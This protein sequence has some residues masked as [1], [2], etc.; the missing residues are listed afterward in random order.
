MPKSSSPPSSDVGFEKYPQSQDNSSFPPTFT[1]PAEF[2][3]WWEKT[4]AQEE[5]NLP[6]SYDVSHL[7]GLNGDMDQPKDEATASAASRYDLR[8][9]KTSPVDNTVKSVIKTS[10]CSQKNKTPMNIPRSPDTPTRP[11]KAKCHSDR[12]VRPVPAFAVCE[13]KTVSNFNRRDT[14]E[15]TD[16]ES[17]SQTP[18]WAASKRARQAPQK[19]DDDGDEL[20]YVDDG[21]APAA[22][23]IL[24]VGEASPDHQHSAADPDL[25]G[26]MHGLAGGV[27]PDPDEEKK[28][29]VDNDVKPKRKNEDD[30]DDEADAHTVKKIKPSASVTLQFSAAG[31]TVDISVNCKINGRNIK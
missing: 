7:V 18:L 4:R 25:D 5:A 28:P 31:E 26:P 17:E 13:P 24:D 1:Y 29:V 6:G 27:F 9:R 19:N 22:N 14:D 20:E 15:I 30:P 11:S 2:E 23:A 12:P 16:T 10:A 8:S 21:P 3:I